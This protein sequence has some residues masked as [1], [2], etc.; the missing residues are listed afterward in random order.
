MQVVFFSF[1]VFIHDRYDEMCSRDEF[2]IS[3]IRKTKVF[4]DSIF[5]LFSDE[6]QI[7]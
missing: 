1:S 3:R 5:R 4:H 7:L 6:N 2:R